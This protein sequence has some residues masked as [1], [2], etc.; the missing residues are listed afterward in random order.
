MFETTSGIMELDKALFWVGQ[1]TPVDPAVNTPERA[2]LVFSGPEFFVALVAGVVLAF[3][4]QLLLTNLSVAA[5]ISYLGHQSDSSSNDDNESGSLG[6]TIRKIG[7]AVGIWTLVTVTIAL[8]IACFLAVKLTLVSSSGLGAIIGLVIWAT[9]FCLLFW[10]SSTTV[11]SLVGSVVN[12][13]TSGFQAIVGT[14][15]AAIGAQAVNNQVVSTAEAA[16]AAVRRELGSGIDPSSIR[17]TLEDY[18]G[19]LR[20]PELDMQKIRGEF[21]RLLSDPQLKAIANT[22]NLRNIDRQTFVNL[23][24]DRT[25]LSKR[26][27]NRIVDQLE[28]VWRQAVGSREQQPD[29]MGELLN[30][31]KSAQPGQ[32]KSDDINAK[33]DQL[34]AEMRDSKKSDQKSADEAAPGPIQLT[35]QQGLTS[36]M[37]LAM[38]RTDLSDLDVQTIL[39][40]LSKAKNKV[41][42]QTDKLATQAGVKP[43][44]PYST[45]RADVENYLLNTYSW[46]ITRPGLN[47]EFK[48]VIYDPQADPGTIRRELEQLDRGYFAN[49]L[50]QRGVFTQDKIND[51]ADQLEGIR[52]EVLVTVRAAEEEEKTQDM[53]RRVEE[54]IQTAPTTELTAP[55]I[56]DNF[57]RVLEDSDADHETLERRLALYDRYA[58]MQLLRGRTDIT[59]E[60]A[61]QISA[62]LEQSRDRV[63]IESQALQDRVKSETEALWVNLESYLRNTGKDELNPE[64]IQRD[65][66][67]LLSDPQAGLSALQ[68]RGSRFDRDTLVQLLSQRQDLSEDQV[69]QIIDQV[70]NSWSNVVHAPQMVMDKAK[71]Q[72]D[73]TSTALTDYLRNTGKDELNP[74]GIQRDL[75]RLL[76]DPKQG[77]TALRQRLSQV[78]RDTLVKLLSQRQDLSEEQVNQVIDQVQGTIK[79]IVKA[80]RRFATRTQTQIQD[81]QSTLEDYLRNTGKDELNPEAIKRDLQLLLHDPRTGVESIT[82]RLSHI[83]RDTMISLVSQRQDISEEEATRI[84]DQVLSVRDQFVEQ[85]RSIQRRIQDTVDGIFAQIRN[86][87]NSLDRPELNYDSI[88]KDVRQL[89]DDPQA[90]FDSLKDRLSHFDRNTLVAIMSSREDISEADANRLVDQIEGARNSVLQRVDRLQQQAQRR[91][92]EVKYQAQRQA[93]ETRKA[94]ASAAWWLFGTAA[95]SGIVS[96]I[97]GALAVAGTR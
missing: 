17:E 4:L 59:E 35:V 73:K 72:V 71:Q 38:G 49:L 87:L 3:A 44:L 64:G 84:V 58:L 10:V 51:I 77:A 28:G 29:R 43:E 50:Q 78:D 26:D 91:L 68:A 15:T 9:Y 16:A 18:L 75:T 60:Q 7:T 69:N 22:D 20:P 65:L 54:Y 74:E 83:D 41:T 40:S 53:R 62:N 6:G 52:Q 25:D 37:G 82:D 80:P 21:E 27:L 92:D 1:L 46:Q 63:L 55:G 24:S 95:V 89:F 45:I 39:S 48:E 2:A 76:S 96:A 36:L 67:T 57:K 14:A 70:Q 11:G 94:A 85:I 47:R 88:K 66:K 86:Y 33:L 19:G 93:E 13:A 90:G 12:T 31:L 23:V 42:E 81:F 61:D 30:Y 97:A 34:I 32:V 8:A 56:N 5:G 79:N